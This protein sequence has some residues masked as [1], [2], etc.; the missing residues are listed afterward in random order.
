MASDKRR[1]TPEYW[2]ARLK[3]MGL[4]IDAGEGVAWLTPKERRK[5]GTECEDGK[6][7]RWLQYGH[8]VTD[9]D[10]DGRETYPLTGEGERLKEWP[11]SL[12]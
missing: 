5:L 7:V 9:L 8:T 11:Q 3:R 2:E 12:M 6:P 10:F 1:D 4:T